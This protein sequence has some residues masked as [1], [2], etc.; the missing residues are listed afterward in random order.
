MK[1]LS[2]H[3]MASA[4]DLLAGLSS[5]LTSWD[6]GASLAYDAVV[7]GRTHSSA[8]CYHAFG[9]QQLHWEVGRSFPWHHQSFHPT[10]DP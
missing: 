3:H 10:A 1:Q 4:E 8:A 9:D 2:L 7:D 6:R 5:G